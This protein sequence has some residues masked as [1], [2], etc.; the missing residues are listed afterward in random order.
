MNSTSSS[1]GPEQIDSTFENIELGAPAEKGKKEVPQ[2]KSY[3]APTVPIRRKHFSSAGWWQ[4]EYWYA[5]LCVITLGFL[6][7]LLK[8]CRFL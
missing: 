7:L 3:H 4:E 2:R 5:G 6:V 1:A 8:S